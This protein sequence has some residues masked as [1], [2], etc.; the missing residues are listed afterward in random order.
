MKLEGPDVDA[1]INRLKEEDQGPFRA[2]YEEYREEIRD[3]EV[4]ATIDQRLY[5]WRKH[6]DLVVSVASGFSPDTDSIGDESRFIFHSTDP[7]TQISSSG[8]DVLLARNELRRIH[9]CVVV[10]EIGDERVG[11]WVD[12]VNNSYSMFEEDSSLD[13]I[14]DQLGFPEKDIGEVQYV[15]LSRKT[16]L[17]GLPLNDISNRV[18]PDKFAIWSAETTEESEICHEYGNHIH[19]DLRDIADGCFDWAFFGENPIKYTLET[20]PVIPLKKVIF[21]LV[22]AKKTFGTD[23]EP[24]EFNKEDFR[25]KYE[26]YLQIGCNGD[27]KESLVREATADIFELGEQIGIF[28]T[29]TNTVRDYRIMFPGRS[30]DPLEAQEA[31]KEKYIS[32]AKEVQR[33]TLAFERA[34]TD[35]DSLQAD[36]DKWSSDDSDISWEI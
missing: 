25:E 31:V 5:R 8:A 12:N 14:C 9:L 2:A 13:R 19:R 29:E 30:E 17:Q 3:E 7:L 4:E 16:D 36:L 20:H 22:R 27:R 33:T 10:C 24:L 1:H 21:G 18:M 15:L 26:S 34:N 6:V 35:F 32:L 11:D 28:S 23:P